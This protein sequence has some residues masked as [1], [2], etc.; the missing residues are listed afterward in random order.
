MSF[1]SPTFAA[2]LEQYEN[3]I[4]KFYHMRKRPPTFIARVARG[5]HDAEFSGFGIYSS[6]VSTHERL[7][8]DRFF[9][10]LRKDVAQ[11]DTF[12][13]SSFPVLDDDL[14]HL[15]LESFAAQ[16]KHGAKYR[17]SIRDAI[18]SSSAILL[19]TL[20][21][22]LDLLHQRIGGMTP[23]RHPFMVNETRVM[24]ETPLDA[25]RIFLSLNRPDLFDRKDLLEN[26]SFTVSRICQVRVEDALF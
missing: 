3:R 17:L 21:K 15:T 11:I 4:S 16:S 5:T 2:L 10:I 24:A 19:P 23:G 7:A 22:K 18:L 12:L 1:D 13:R 14:F 6:D 26:N 20:A 8:R 25:L 9:K